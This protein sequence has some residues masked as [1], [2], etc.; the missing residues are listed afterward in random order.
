MYNGSVLY[1]ADAL[2]TLIDGTIADFYE[3]RKDTT[4]LVYHQTNFV[5]RLN[6]GIV[7]GG[8]LQDADCLNLALSSKI[9][10][11]LYSDIKFK[12]ESL[13]NYLERYIEAIKK[14]F[15]NFTSSVDAVVI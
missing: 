2:F 1:K 5:K 11:H 8:F 7:R 13:A 12:A 6:E 15:K 10:T 14:E 4:D 3:S 9:I